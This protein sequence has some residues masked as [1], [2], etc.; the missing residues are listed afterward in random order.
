MYLYTYIYIYILCLGWGHKFR[1]CA[2][3]RQNDGFREKWNLEV[4]KV[5]KNMIVYF[6]EKIW[7]KQIK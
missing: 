2:T 4:G 3:M 1:I 5:F 7:E 6:L